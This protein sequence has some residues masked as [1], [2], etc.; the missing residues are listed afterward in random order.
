MKHIF[1]SI[2]L[3]L[4]L[5]VSLSSFAQDKKP[6]KSYIGITGGVSAPSGNFVKGDYDND[7]SGFAGTGAAIGLTGVY[8]FKS[9]FGIGGLATYNG[10]GFK[11]AQQLADGYKEAFDVDSSTVKV[12]GSNHTLNILVGPYYAFP[13][14]KK[15]SLDLRVL[16]GLVNASL[17]GNKVYLEDN[18]DATFGQ[19]KSTA[20][21]FGF[22]AGAGLRYAIAPHLAL[23]LNVDY[24]SSKP[25][26]K[27]SNENRPVNAGRL[28]TRYHE[29]ISGINGNLGVAYQF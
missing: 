22:Q 6:V 1:S 4:L 3:L 28:I 15:L 11:G 12:D 2:S 9:G 21:A 17:A 26:F 27:V 5:T 29:S 19:K 13:L 7:K 10:Y 20:S 23:L 14:G 18:T 25:D 8:Y 24:F 16:G